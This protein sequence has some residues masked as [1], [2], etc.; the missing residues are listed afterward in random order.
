MTK[1]NNKFEWTDES[2]VAFEKLKIALED[3][4]T[5]SYPYP[6]LPCIVDSDASDVAIGAVL[7]QVIEGEE[8]PIAFYSRIMSQ[9]QRN[10]CPTR[11]ELLAAVS[12]VQ[13]FR[14]YLFGNK[15]TLRTDHHSLKWLNTFKRPDG[16]LARWIDTS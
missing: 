12:A 11:R 9:T 5:L 2:Q 13:H 6:N 4:T 15:V 1:K 10:Y 3:A 16:I 14:H 8:R 7:S